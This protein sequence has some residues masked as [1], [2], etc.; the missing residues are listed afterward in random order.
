LVE[1]PAVVAMTATNNQLAASRRRFMG[2]S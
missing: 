1:Q 2:A